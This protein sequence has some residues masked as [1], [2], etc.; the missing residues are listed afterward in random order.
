MSSFYCEYCN[1]AIID[2]LRGYVTGC[3]HYPLK[4]KI[5]TQCPDCLAHYKGRHECDGL[6][7]SLVGFNKGKLKDEFINYGGFEVSNKVIMEQPKEW[8][9]EF[10]DFYWENGKYDGRELG[11]VEHKKFITHLLTQQKEEIMSE[12]FAN[13]YKSSQSY[14]RGYED[15][16]HNFK[17]QVID[18]INLRD[19]LDDYDKALI[20]YIDKI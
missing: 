12:K 13:T 4:K 10:E 9:E 6:M 5:A 1:K 11:I 16:N 3:E 18:F 15:G 8:E 20:S 7:K 17:K 19:Y 2:A 14:L